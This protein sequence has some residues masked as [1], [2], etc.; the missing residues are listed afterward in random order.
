MHT[1]FLGAVDVVCKLITVERS[2]VL[3]KRTSGVY[4]RV[5]GVTF[6]VDNEPSVEDQTAVVDTCNEREGD[7]WFCVPFMQRCE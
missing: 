5:V 7:D 4:H 2:L 3:G 1:Y 6:R